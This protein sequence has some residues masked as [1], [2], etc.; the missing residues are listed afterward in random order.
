MISPS[1]RNEEGISSSLRRS[2]GFVL[3]QQSPAGYWEDFEF[4]PFPGSSQAWVTAYVIRCLHPHLAK[5]EPHELIPSITKAGEWLSS[6]VSPTGGWGYNGKTRDDADS[7]ANAVLA[8]KAL[9]LPIPS[10]CA[11]RLRSFRTP[12]NAFATF[13]RRSEN[14][15]WG[16]KHV[17]VTPVCLEASKVLGAISQSDFHKGLKFISDSQSANGLWMSYWWTT[18]LYPTSECARILSVYKQTGFSESLKSALSIDRFQSS[19][20][21]AALL[22]E[23]H[24][25]IGSPPDITNDILESLLSSQMPDGSWPSSQMLR[26]TISDIRDP[27]N[28]AGFVG[29][30]SNDRRRIFTSATVIRTL[31]VLSRSHA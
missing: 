3:S 1:T 6:A 25:I 11:E 30:V 29:H 18:N 8:L 16:S 24:S 21:E 2:I 27:W 10:Q 26:N 31:S 7:T 20:F 9:N 22:A 19:C 14:D 17:D 12:D 4:I 13:H 23:L 5:Y 15:N 28:S